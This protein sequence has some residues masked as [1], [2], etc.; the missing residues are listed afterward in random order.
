MFPCQPPGSSALV[1]ILWTSAQ[2]SSPTSALRG[3][4]RYASS[5]TSSAL[6]IYRHRHNII[7]R[8]PPALG[9]IRHKVP[10][11]VPRPDPTSELSFKYDACLLSL[12]SLTPLVLLPPSHAAGLASSVSPHARLDVHF[13]NPF[14][15]QKHSFSN[16]PRNIN[17]S[18]LHN[19]YTQNSISHRLPILRR[20][21]TLNHV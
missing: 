19:Q 18:S 16:P 3:R 4:H 17:I 21:R 11:Q 1:A 5:P 9:V 14:P 10:R 12:T 13:Q 6:A 20:V 8:R 7:P 15:F 2:C